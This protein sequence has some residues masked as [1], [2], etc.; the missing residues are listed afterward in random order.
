L[1]VY[2]FVGAEEGKDQQMKR[3]SE[4]AQRCDNRFNVFVGR[5]RPIGSALTSEEWEKVK[6]LDL[7][8]FEN[9]AGLMAGGQP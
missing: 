5:E 3:F 4:I 6:L 8:K 7:W 2:A 1:T 9:L